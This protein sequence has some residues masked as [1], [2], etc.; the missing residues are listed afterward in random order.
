MTQFGCPPSRKP[1]PIR[2]G[3]E[4]KA[5]HR[6]EFANR[7]SLQRNRDMT[8]AS[9]TENGAEDMIAMASEIVAAYASNNQ[10][11]SGDLPDLIRSVHSTLTGLGGG[12]PS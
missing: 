1:D 10:M 5:F 2:F 4:T 8:E 7:T 6:Y 3:M 9:E 11:A 12:D